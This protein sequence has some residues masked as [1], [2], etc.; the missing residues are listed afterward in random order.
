ML[1]DFAGAMLI[2][3]AASILFALAWCVAFRP[4]ITVIHV[5]R[6]PGRLK[7]FLAGT[8]VGDAWLCPRCKSLWEWR[9]KGF[10]GDEVRWVRILGPAGERV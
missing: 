9:E 6:T 3:L 10:Y 4:R 8:H 1:D 7:R 2:W 5:C